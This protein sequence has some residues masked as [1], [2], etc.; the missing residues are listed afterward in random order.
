M[1]VIIA[2]LL[3]LS[4]LYPVSIKA[5]QTAS[6]YSGAI[7]NSRQ[8]SLPELPVHLNPGLVYRVITPQLEI[9]LPPKDQA[10]GIAVII[11]PGGSYKVLTYEAEGV[12]TAKELSKHGIAAFVLKYRLPDDST[13]VD[14]K[15]GPLQ[16]AQQAI[17]LVRENARLWGVDTCRVGMMGFSAGGH[18]AASAATHFQHALIE[19]KNKTNLR[20]DFLILVYPVISM[21]DS[22]THID[23]R[24]NLLG[25]HPSK[26]VIDLFSNELQVDHNTPPT[27]I[28]HAG[29]D[30]L[31]DVD[32]SIVFYERLRHNNVS[33]QLMLY[34]KGGHGFVLGLPAEVWLDPIYQWIKSK[35]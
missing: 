5:Q 9:Y 34:P 23:S 4:I 25:K 22:L 14:K 6:L 26:S 11:C 8:G 32:N 2:S 16:D 31:V 27:Y 30:K 35:R 15:I 19:N 29:D 18:L 3:L 10:T 20:P 33:A 13:M 28:T 24:I 21:Q 17:K 7:P 1:R 12:R